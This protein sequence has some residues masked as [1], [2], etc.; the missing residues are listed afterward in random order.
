MGAPWIKQGLL[1][2]NGRPPWDR[3]ECLHLQRPAEQAAAHRANKR[4]LRLEQQL[5]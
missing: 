4:L 5:Q 3:G 1:K 2:R